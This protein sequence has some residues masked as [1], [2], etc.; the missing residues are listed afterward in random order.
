MKRIA[1]WQP[2]KLQRNGAGFLVRSEGVG[3]GSLL[4]AL[5]MSE[6]LVPL[7]RELSG[8][9]VDLGAGR[10]PFY[11]VYAPH[12]EEAICVDWSNSLH[13]L[14][15]ADVIANL[16]RPL[17]FAPCSFDGA[18]MSSVLE[19]L[20][21]PAAALGEVARILRP[22]GKLV[23]ELPFLYWLHEEPYD[24]GR[25]TEHWLRRAAGCAGL[26]VDRIQPYG[27]LAA[28]SGDV[29]AKAVQIAA[30]R[31]RGYLPA[32]M[33][34]AMA[35]LAAWINRRGQ[36]A[37]FHCFVSS[38]RRGGA[39]RSASKFPL[40]YVAVFSKPRADARAEAGE[41]T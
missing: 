41:G 34:R 31:L 3:P 8:R 25:Y 37:V 28:V 2:T 12:I 27:G 13:G 23:V 15:H 6:A 24:F 21:D 4:M 29:S 35:R 18:I 11:E 17:P 9:I 36:R 33:G 10:V 30:D 39:S 7:L 40:G 26:K 32:V 16:D 22:G 5:S 1:E 19:H 20:S 14:T 38:A